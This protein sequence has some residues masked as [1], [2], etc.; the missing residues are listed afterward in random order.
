[1]M[2][3]SA[4]RQP[5]KQGLSDLERLHRMLDQIVDI[6]L[7]IECMR[8]SLQAVL[9]MGL[10]SKDLSKEAPSGYR[11]FSDTMHTLPSG[12]IRDHHTNLELIVNMQLNR[13]LNYSSIDFSSAEGSEFTT[14]GKSDPQRPLELLH[15][16]KRTAQTAVA[17]RMLLHKRGL[18]TPG[19]VLSAS[20]EELKRRLSQLDRQL[21]DQRRRITSQIEVVETEIVRLIDNP[22]NADAMK[23]VLHEEAANLDLDLQ[24][25]AEGGSIDC[26]S[27]VAMNDETATG[28]A[29]IG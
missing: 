2:S 29:V 27:F 4:D 14:S 1:M 21:A 8:E 19:S 6:A 17:L 28:D 11:T 15:A 18:P 16:F 22:H 7:A 20:N 24:L 5:Q 3:V 13:I 23:S 26:L 12:E 25:L 10:A 9:L